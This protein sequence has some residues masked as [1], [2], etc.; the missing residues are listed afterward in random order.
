MRRGGLSVS[1]LHLCCV[2]WAL[3]GMYDSVYLLN[4]QGPQLLWGW[5]APL[6]SLW[7]WKVVEPEKL[8][9]Y[10]MAREARRKLLKNPI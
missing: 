10:R 4:V 5:G 3:S 2:G 8:L 7:F 9:L 6:A 1:S